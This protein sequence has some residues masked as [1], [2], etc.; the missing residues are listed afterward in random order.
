MSIFILIG[1][2]NK[3]AITLQVSTIFLAT[4]NLLELKTSTLSGVVALLLSV[5]VVLFISLFSKR[6]EKRD[7]KSF[8]EK[9]FALNLTAAVDT[10]YLLILSHIVIAAIANFKGVDLE[11]DVLASSLVLAFFNILFLFFTSQVFI[12]HEQQRM[13]RKIE[14][15]T[16]HWVFTF[17]S[18]VTLVGVLIGVF[19]VINGF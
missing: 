16:R 5:F 9:K 14:D 12:I 7:I 1:L 15:N 13:G 8:V 11:I 10:L 19:L 2:I 18:V 17:M 3:T 4:I 6:I